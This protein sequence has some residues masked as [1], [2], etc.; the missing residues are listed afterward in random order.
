MKSQT[1]IETKFDV[2]DDVM[3]TELHS[4]DGVSS[5]A[6]PVEFDLDV[7]QREQHAVRERC[8]PRPATRERH[9]KRE[10]RGVVSVARCR[11]NAIPARGIDA[12]ERSVPGIVSAA[13][14][15]AR[16][17]RDRGDTA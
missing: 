11:A 9:G 2:D 1:E 16:K 15:G 4:I 14:K 7:S 6:A 17:S 13:G 3:V 8:G 10:L 5:A 12:L